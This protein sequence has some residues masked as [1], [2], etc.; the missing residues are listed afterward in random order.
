MT[1]I[2]HFKEYSFPYPA[3]CHPYVDVM[4]TYDPKKV[5]CGNCKRTKVFKQVGRVVI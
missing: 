1:P 3:A 5:T 4:R 2:I